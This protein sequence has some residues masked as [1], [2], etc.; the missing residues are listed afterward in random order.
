M[1]TV[2]VH[3]PAHASTAQNSGLLLMPEMSGRLRSMS[4]PYECSFISAAQRARVRSQAGGGCVVAISAELLPWCV[5]PA[6]AAAPQAPAAAAAEAAPTAQ[7]GSTQLQ[8]TLDSVIIDRYDL[9]ADDITA[10]REEMQGTGPHARLCWSPSSDAASLL[11][12]C[13]TLRMLT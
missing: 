8:L 9:A 2:P 13:F 4:T 5:S 11:K 3:G 12:T 7:P 1:L 6:T 10:M